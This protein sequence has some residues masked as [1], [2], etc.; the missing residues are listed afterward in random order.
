MESSRYPQNSAINLR[1]KKSL[2]RPRADSSS[3]NSIPTA[4]TKKSALSQRLLSNSNRDS[5]SISDDLKQTPP[6]VL[7]SAFKPPTQRPRPTPLRWSRNPPM[8]EY[9]FTRIT[10]LLQE[11]GNVTMEKSQDEETIEIATDWIKGETAF[12]AK[13]AYEATGFIGRGATKRAIYV[14]H[15]LVQ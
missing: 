13:E 12:H 9:R 15:S 11:N 2:K 7:R 10:A 8:Q 5:D 1:S 14:R 3:P 6:I 4:A